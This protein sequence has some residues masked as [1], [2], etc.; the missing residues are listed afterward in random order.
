[1]YCTVPYG[2][3]RERYSVRWFKGLTE[4]LPD[5]EGFENFRFGEDGALEFSNVQISDTS[6]AYYCNVSVDR[7]DGVVSRQGSTI[8]L[9][10]L[11]KCT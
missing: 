3:V 8:E 6:R 1:M 9:S 11:G 10:V 4:I 7:A 5:T 2:V